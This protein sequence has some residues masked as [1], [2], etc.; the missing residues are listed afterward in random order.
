M[1]KKYKWRKIKEFEQNDLVL[2]KNNKMGKGLPKFLGPFRVT[3]KLNDLNYVIKIILENGEET[4]DTVHIKRL[5]EYKARKNA[6]L[7]PRIEGK[8][9]EE[10]DTEDTPLKGKGAVLEKKNKKRKLKKG[11][12]GNLRDQEEGLG[13]NLSNVIFLILPNGKRV[14]SKPSHT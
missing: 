5:Y 1:H 13:R 8:S 11:N 4:K 7:L 2:L 10:T 6:K 9:K 12:L 3:K 14:K